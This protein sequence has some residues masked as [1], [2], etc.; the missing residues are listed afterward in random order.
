MLEGVSSMNPEC[1]WKLKMRSVPKKVLAA[2]SMRMSP[3]RRRPSAPR[4]RVEPPS[5]AGGIPEDALR[6]EDA[7]AFITPPLG[8]PGAELRLVSTF[9]CRRKL[10]LPGDAPLEG[11]GGGGEA[12]ASNDLGESMEG[13]VPTSKAPCSIMRLLESSP[14]EAHFIDKSRL[15]SVSMTHS[16]FPFSATMP[17][18]RYSFTACAFS[19]SMTEM[20]RMWGASSDLSGGGVMTT[21]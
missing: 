4:Y 2:I 11:C 10:T 21:L 9:S 19:S 6:S 15:E 3:A 20:E 16:H 7:I 18:D 17:C 12:G 1:I 8:A 5:E 14:S 13:G